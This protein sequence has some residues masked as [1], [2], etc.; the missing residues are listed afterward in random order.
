M[1]NFIGNQA[2]VFDVHHRFQGDLTG[3]HPTTSNDPALQDLSRL[4]T[5]LIDEMQ[6]IYRICAGLLSEAT[7]SNELANLF[8]N[9]LSS[10][11]NR[12]R[13]KLLLSKQ[14][15]PG[16][17]IKFIALAPALIYEVILLGPVLAPQGRNSV[18]PS[19][20]SIIWAR[21]D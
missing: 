7:T 19:V 14:L 15:V 6:K 20:S 8:L 21:R 18:N 17:D 1:A 12:P 3:I 2:S 13:I 5:E 4:Q 10:E 9:F 11:R 16:D